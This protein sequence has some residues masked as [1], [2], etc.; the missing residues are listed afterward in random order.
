MEGNREN[1]EGQFWAENAV[2][3]GDIRIRDA[4]VLLLI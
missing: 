1:G 2:R 3:E 4:G